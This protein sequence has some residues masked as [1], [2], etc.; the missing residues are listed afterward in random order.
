MDIV[1]PDSLSSELAELLGIIVGDGYI[2]RN[3]NWLSIETSSEERPYMEEYVI[4]LFNDIFKTSVKGRYFNRNGF[5]NTFGFYAC[6]K[7][8]VNFFDQLEVACKHNV[9]RV[10]SV[11][12][13][14]TQ[15]EIITSFIRGYVDTDGCLSFYKPNKSNA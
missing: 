8:L 13:K 6:S 10:P 4:P 3:P 15:H 2:R 14:S 11:I 9:I 1:A 7:E 12:R 5:Q